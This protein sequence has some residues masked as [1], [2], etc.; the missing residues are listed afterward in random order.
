MLAYL[1]ENNMLDESQRLLAFYILCEMYHHENVQ[2]TPLMPVI[3]RTLQQYQE[4]KECSRAEA[5]LLQEFLVSVPKVA[6]LT[7]EEFLKREEEAEELKI[8]DIRNYLKKH[9]QHMPGVVGFEKSALSAVIID[10][11][12][13]RGD[14]PDNE[15]PPEGIDPAE[16]SAEELEAQP[17]KAPFVRPLPVAEFNPGEDEEDAFW[18]IPG[19]LPE[20]YWDYNLG[21]E[22]SKVRTLLKKA[23]KTTLE[24]DEEQLVMQALNKDRELVFHS[25][26]LPKD[27]PELVLYNPHVAF[28][29]LLKLTHC[30]YIEEYYMQLVNMKMNLHS[31]EV[32]NKLTNIV[33]LPKEYL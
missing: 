30:Q 3:I 10:N 29:F 12:G 19:M 25:Y 1:L 7:I 26:I 28:E 9:E 21:E 22:P 18:L 5:K 31:L 8:P 20:P 2:T 4:R 15:F 16:I 32:F 23:L 11:E 17:F 33:E 13:R 24:Q 6:K 14:G 27:L